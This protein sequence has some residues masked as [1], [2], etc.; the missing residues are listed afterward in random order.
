M[1]NA[2]GSLPT[3]TEVIEVDNAVAPGFEATEVAPLGSDSDFHETRS[4]SSPSTGVGA[5]SAAST[6]IDHVI[7]AALPRIDGL[8]EARLREVV[9]PTLARQVDMALK[10]AR[11]DLRV[12]LRELVRQVLKEERAG[13]SER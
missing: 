4:E 13:H 8:L 12:E 2:R 10:A 9:A 1:T 5:E 7:A 11:A 3:L 6:L